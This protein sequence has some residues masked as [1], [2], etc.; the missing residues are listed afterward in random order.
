MNT[1]DYPNNQCVYTKLQKQ[2]LKQKLGDLQ[3]ID[4]TIE[5]NMH[6]TADNSR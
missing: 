6:F 5:S 1:S 4:E 3:Q 2:I